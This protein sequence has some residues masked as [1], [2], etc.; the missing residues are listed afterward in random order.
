M[1]R[2]L[3]WSVLVLLGASIYVDFAKTDPLRIVHFAVGKGDATLIISP[4]DSTLLVDAGS[5]TYGGDSAAAIIGTY[6]VE[7]G[8]DSLFYT[9]ATHFHDDHING[10][11]TLFE[12]YGYQPVIAYDRGSPGLDTLWYNCA[13]YDDY[14]DYVENEGIRDSIFAGDTIDLGSGVTLTA[15]YSNGDFLNGRSDPL[16]LRREF[17]NVRSICLLMKYNN[18][19]YVV[20]GDLTGYGGVFADKETPSAGLIGDIDVFQVNH[21]G[22]GSSTNGN[23]LDVLRPEAAVVSADSTMVCQAM[24]D[25]IDACLTMET[26]YHT[27]Y[28][29]V[30]GI[31]SRIVNGNILLETDG[32]TYYI[33]DGDTFSINDELPVSVSVTPDPSY[34]SIPSGGGNFEFDIE[35]T[36]NSSDTVRS[37]CWTMWHSQG[38]WRQAMD[39]ENVTLA[40]DTSII[41]HRV[42][43]LPEICNSGNYIYEARVGI[44]P[45]SI[46]D[47]DSFPVWKD[48]IEAVDA[49]AK[50]GLTTVQTSGEDRVTSIP[51]GDVILSTSPNPFNP[52]TTITI[53]L[54]V[55]AYM[56][57]RVYDI[58]GRIVAELDCGWRE[59]G[60]H[61]MTFDGASLASGIYIYQLEVGEFSTS[62]KMVLMK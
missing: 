28:S 10:F 41:Y 13:H 29:T 27:E 51:A 24:V 39:A 17:E 44:Y 7:Q 6:L 20:A 18:F 58:T 55:S 4:S 26:L 30:Q 11:T 8:I 33:V 60:V 57:L 22:G 32:F 21:H 45:D 2:C 59:A 56:D 53:K 54:P 23:W 12:A 42:G 14:I 40:P 61:E 35:L 43:N 9:L 47:S 3:L 52:V 50:Q 36:N 25:R 15:V 19:S 16:R 37:N 48:T 49:A 34:I 38:R 46:W 5:E 1:K 62:G 31:K